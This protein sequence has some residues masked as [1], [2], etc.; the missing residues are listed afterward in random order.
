VLDVQ[1][2]AVRLRVP[3]D[4][5]DLASIAAFVRWAAERIR[6]DVPATP[7]AAVVLDLGDV[8]L[9]MAAGVAALLDLDA[10]LAARG[11]TLHVADPAPIVARVF[12]ICD[13]PE[14]W[15]TT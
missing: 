5:L 14:R 15:L 7:G 13:V 3:F 2:E 9:V 8:E 10:A 12:A 1:R 4:A 6:D 11:Q